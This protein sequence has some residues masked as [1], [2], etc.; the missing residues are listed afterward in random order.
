MYE[1]RLL[2][3]RPDESDLVERRSCM[4]TVNGYKVVAMKRRDWDDAPVV[5]CDRGDVPHGRYVTWVINEH[6]G[7][8]FL[9]H[10]IEGGLE[11]G[12]ASLNER[13]TGF[14]VHNG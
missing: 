13:T 2:R 12:M 4:F 3:D 14:V 1:R 6:N 7:A 10:Y 5:L 8:A 9:G 11:A